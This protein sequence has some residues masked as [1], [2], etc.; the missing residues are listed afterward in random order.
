MVADQVV[1]RDTPLKCLIGSH[2][3]GLFLIRDDRWRRRSGDLHASG[4]MCLIRA[5]IG[6]IT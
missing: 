3:L 4:D 5:D 6:R 1:P 2:L